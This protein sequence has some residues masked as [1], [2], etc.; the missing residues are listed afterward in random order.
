MKSFFIISFLFVVNS[1]FSQNNN[2]HWHDIIQKN[3]IFYKKNK[4]EPFNGK[5]F[6]SKSG[7]M[8]YGVKTGIWE[9]F[10]K[11]NITESIGLYVDG[12]KNEIWRYFYQT[13]NLQSKIYYL[14]NLRNGIS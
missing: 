6:G 5:V 9:N 2:V 1:V 7:I 4:K 14:N 3:K 12:K 11:T 13:G 8:K 10:Y